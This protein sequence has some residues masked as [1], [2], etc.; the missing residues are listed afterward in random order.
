MDYYKRTERGRRLLDE[1]LTKAPTVKFSGICLVLIENLELGERFVRKR[2]E[3]LEDNGLVKVTRD[4]TGKIV[5]VSKVGQ[6][7]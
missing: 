4:K 7:S 1:C 6:S 3:M 5:E 2:I